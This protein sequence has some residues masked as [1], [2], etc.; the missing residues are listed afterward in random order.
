IATT[1]PS[2]PHALPISLVTADAT[3]RFVRALALGDTRGLDDRDWDILRIT[4]LTHLIAIS[5]FHVGL[6]AGFGA[7]LARLAWWLLPG[8]GRYWPRPLAAAAAA[9]L[10]AAVYTA[11]AGFALPT[12]RTL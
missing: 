12:L 11:L 2:L 9:L 1:M 10:A 8:V 5:G 6:V 3:A 4:G 7:V